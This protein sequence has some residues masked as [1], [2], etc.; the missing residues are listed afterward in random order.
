MAEMITKRF[1][2]F[3]KD[4]TFSIYLSAGYIP[5]DSLV[6]IKE[7]GKIYMNGVYYSDYETIRQ[8]LFENGKGSVN[9]R[10]ALL[11]KEIIDGASETYDTLRKIQNFLEEFGK[12][13]IVEGDGIEISDEGDGVQK[14]SVKVDQTSVTFNEN[15]ELAVKDVDGGV[16]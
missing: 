7:T 15:K 4:S 10:I 9:E 2:E 13:R 11:K 8:A 1:V 14:I 5:R 3:D 12:K 16:F 6:F